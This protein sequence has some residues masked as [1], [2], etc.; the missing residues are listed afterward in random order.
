MR[1]YVDCEKL[2]GDAIMNPGKQQD[3]LDKMTIHQI[4]CHII[5]CP[6]CERVM[7]SKKAVLVEISHKDLPVKD[8]VFCGFDCANSSVEQVRA[9]LEKNDCTIRIVSPW[10]KAKPKAQKK[11][12]VDKM[13]DKLKKERDS[14]AKKEQQVIE[15]ARLMNPDYID[16]STGNERMVEMRIESK[17]KLVGKFCGKASMMVPEARKLAKYFAKRNKSVCHIISSCGRFNGAEER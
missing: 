2:I 8:H 12:F 9:R 10:A 14:K 5:F 17:G 15:K 7:D 6:S 3:S 4:V 16:P 1:N 13:V 11:S